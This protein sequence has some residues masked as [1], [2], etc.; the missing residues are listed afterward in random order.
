M[1]R[2]IF[3]KHWLFALILFCA[4]TLSSQSQNIEAFIQK[5][6][7]Y[8][9]SVKLIMRGDSTS[10]DANTFDLK[11]YMQMFD[12]LKL[13][14]GLQY[15]YWFMDNVLDGRPYIYS[16]K[17][18]FNLNDYYEQLADENG[19]YKKQ[20]RFKAIHRAKFEFVSKPENKASNHVIPEDSR[21]GYV[22]YLFFHEFGEQFVLMWHE[23][24]NAKSVIP[25]MKSKYIVYDENLDGTN[26]PEERGKEIYPPNIIIPEISAELNPNSC[27]VTWY[28][29]ELC[30]GTFLRTYTVERKAPY[31]IR[32]ISEK[33]IMAASFTGVW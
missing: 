11:T 1:R 13:E 17:P 9:A 26:I 29:N 33:Q 20:E 14:S 25:S 32:K 2:P 22:Q 16:H 15:N 28:E 8:Q 5:V 10:I 3:N 6:Q 18:S 27:K 21:E 23:A 31:I 7:A 4:G 12:K 19:I 24:Y 30:H